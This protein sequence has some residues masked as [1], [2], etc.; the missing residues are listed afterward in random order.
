[1]QN[2][3]QINAPEHESPWEDINKTAIIVFPDGRYIYGEGAGAEG[4]ID[5]ELCFNTSMCGY[6]EILTDPS[7]NGQIITFTFP[8]IGNVGI[9]P[10]DQETVPTIKRLGAKGAIFKAAI[11]KPAN[12]RSTQDFNTWLEDENI[13]AI[14]HID[15]RA[16]TQYIRKIGAHNVVIAHN[17]KGQFDL[18]YLIDLAKKS[19]TLIGQDL[20]ATV[21]SEQTSN[22]QE[23]AW[24]WPDG[25]S[26]NEKQDYHIV[27]V[28]YG[29]KRNILRLLANLGAKLTIVPAT[30]SAET[31]LELKP[32]GVFLSN[33]PGDPAATAIYAIPMIKSILDAN[34]PLFGICLGHQLLALAAGAK[35][36]SMAQGHRGA[37]HPVKNLT[38]GQVE[39]VSMNHG[40][41]VDRDSLSD[42][43]IET[44]ISLFDNSNCGL[45]LVNK[46][47]FSVQY[48][49]EASPGP[50]D[51]YYLFNKFQE[52]M[53]K[54]KASK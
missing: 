34:I 17:K 2:S 24:Q 41:T 50:Q 52:L 12:Y 32:D 6:Q 8:H 14:S 27:V 11:T 16:I 7:Y 46:P 39:I 31:I 54:H 3:K 51:S 33:G 15:T 44:H 49:P 48:H 35:T 42:Q 10:E 28:D 23:A 37:N 36:S 9:N 43:I 5:G 19:P 29:V 45:S 25:Y 40:F 21:T 4:I 13:V 26:I 22:W 30:T 47:A 53:A 38:T 1:M 20:A 18:D